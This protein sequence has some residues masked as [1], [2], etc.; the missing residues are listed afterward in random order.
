MSALGQGTLTLD[1][2]SAQLRPDS[3]LW[4]RNLKNGDTLSVRDSASESEP[5]IDLDVAAALSG[6]H[7]P[8]PAS[9]MV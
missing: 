7:G 3:T 1:K 5:D 4:L 9:N 2:G 6:N 8:G